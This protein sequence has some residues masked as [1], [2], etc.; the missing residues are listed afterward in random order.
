MARDF[1]KAFYKSKAWQ[2]CR[3][4]ILKR[5]GYLC[6]KCGYAAEEVHHKK[7]LTPQNIH[8]TSITLNPEN[9]ISL[10]RSCHFDIHRADKAEG[11]RKKNGIPEYE[12]DFDENGMLV[13]KQA[14]GSC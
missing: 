4:F 2:D 9:L 14:D 8:D 1:A 10:C 7:H 13:R 6:V 5:D 12:Y 11:I 3:S